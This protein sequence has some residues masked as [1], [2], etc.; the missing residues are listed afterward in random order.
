MEGA[1]PGPRR[2]GQWKHEHPLRTCVGDVALSVA[3]EAPCEPGLDPV[4]GAVD[5]PVEARRIHEGLQK[6]DLVAEAGRPVMDDAPGAQRQDARAEVAR[7]AGQDQEPGV[8]RDEMQAAELEAAIPA[9][10]AVAV[11]GDVAHGL[12]DRPERASSTSATMSTDTSERS[13]PVLPKLIRRNHTGARRKCSDPR[14]TSC[15]TWKK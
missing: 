14:S 4:R 15:Q 12:A 5:G 13:T 8:V 1:A 3:G 6:Q 2:A 7:R 9:D 10:P 11:T